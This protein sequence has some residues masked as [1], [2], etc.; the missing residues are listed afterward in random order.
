M[1]VTIVNPNS[2]AS[3]TN[4]MVTSAQDTVPHLRFEGWT[5][6]QGPPSIQG[7][8]DGDPMADE[9][10]ALTESLE[11][12]MRLRTGESDVKDEIRYFELC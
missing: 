3:M 4:A 9:N 6:E 8:E 10:D 11:Y 1:P 2:T 7:A 12:S 5:S